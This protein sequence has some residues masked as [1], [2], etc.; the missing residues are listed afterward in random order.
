MITLYDKIT[1]KPVTLSRLMRDEILVTAY[2]K[3][4]RVGHIIIPEV[5]KTDRTQTLWEVIASN[6][7]AEEAL[8]MKLAVG[9]IVQ[10]QRRWP[11]DTHLVTES[12]AP[13]LLLSIEHC[14]IRGVI[15]YE[16]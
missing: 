14:G 7:K 1:R 5:A 11:R 3:P 15:S 12:G 13:A 10:T 2:T 8:G 9:D 6:A 16:D 4:D